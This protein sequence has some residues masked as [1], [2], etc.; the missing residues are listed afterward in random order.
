M[1][2]LENK[3]WFYIVLGT[4]LVSAANAISLSLSPKAED[5]IKSRSDNNKGEIY[6]IDD[7][8][9]IYE[10]KANNVYDSQLLNCATQ[11]AMNHTN[12]QKAYVLIMDY[13]PPIQAPYPYASN[14]KESEL[15]LKDFNLKP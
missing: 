11:I 7:I 15:V 13:C 3:I 1:K 12:T 9:Q 6:L 10:E 5:Y 2:I 8:N 4:V 14:N